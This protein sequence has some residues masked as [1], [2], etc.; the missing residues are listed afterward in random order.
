MFETSLYCFLFL[1]LGNFS[2]S[3]A[4]NLVQMRSIM[5]STKAT[6]FDI[7]PFLEATSRGASIDDHQKAKSTGY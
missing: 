4:G 7:M 3:V 6:A 5:E 2:S 1:C